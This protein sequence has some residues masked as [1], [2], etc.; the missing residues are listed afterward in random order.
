ME[1]RWVEHKELLMKKG[2]NYSHL[3]QIT[4]MNRI[5]MRPGTDTLLKRCYE[6][7][8][9]LIIFSASGIGVDSIKL[10]LQHR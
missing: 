10:L 5:V 4:T 6:Y 9:P 8:I 3:E 2:L 1:K 7:D